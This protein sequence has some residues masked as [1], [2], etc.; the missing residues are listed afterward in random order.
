MGTLKCAPV[1]G[2]L[3]HA[4]ERRGDHALDLLVQD[5]AWSARSRR[6]HEPVSIERVETAPP[7]AHHH[8]AVPQLGAHLP[9]RDSWFGAGARAMCD[10]NVRA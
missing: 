6:L 8:A 2:F 7:F 10:R 1:R 5:R 4:F 3:R 9:V